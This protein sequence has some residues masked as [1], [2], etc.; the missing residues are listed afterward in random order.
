MREIYTNVT[1][2][3]FTF[4]SWSCSPSGVRDISRLAF[5]PRYSPSFPS[6]SFFF[7]AHF[8]STQASINF[9]SQSC[10]A[11]KERIRPKTMGSVNPPMVSTDRRL[12][13]SS[14][15]MKYIHNIHAIMYK[16]MQRQ[17]LFVA[18]IMCNE[19]YKGEQ[20]NARALAPVN[21]DACLQ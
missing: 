20:K 6:L 1:C 7:F 21:A 4:T 2:S 15:E 17:L 9:A 16:Y 8:F 5:S 19:P 18:P 10:D 3:S 11:M 14:A 12:L 13:L